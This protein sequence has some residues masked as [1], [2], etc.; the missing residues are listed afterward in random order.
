MLYSM[1]L[2]MS[3]LE[4]LSKEVKRVLKPN[5][6]NIFTAR[7]KEDPHY[8]KG[9]A[10]GEDMYEADG[11]VVRFFDKETVRSIEEG[12]EITD[13]QEFQEGE[14]PRKLFLVTL[15]KES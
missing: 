7:T 1:A 9:I 3:Q 4:S 6:L 5:G 13:V 12:Y 2:S 14:L 8:A 11:F 10:R 15:R